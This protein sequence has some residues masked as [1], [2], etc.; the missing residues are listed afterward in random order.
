MKKRSQVLD[1]YKLNVKELFNND[2]EFIKEIDKLKKEIKVISKYEGHLLDDPKTLLEMLDY[3]EEIEKRIEKIYI[4][5]HL[6][7]DMDLGDTKGNE[8]YGIAYKL[9]KDYCT[10]SSYVVPEL[11]EY[12][13]KEIDAF[14]KENEKLKKYERSLK[15]I[16]RLKSHMLSK[17]EEYILT[18]LSDTF[19]APEEIYSKLTDVD[20]KFGTVLDENGSEV[21]L[22]ESNW[23]SFIES[24]DRNVRKNVFKKFFSAY[25]GIINT[26]SELLSN[27]VKKNN[28]VSEI[29]KYDSAMARALDSNEVSP[30][31]Y[32]KL[33]SSIEKNLKTIYRQW[34][35][36]KEKLK[37]DELH[38]YDTYVPLTE[39]F[40]KKYTYEEASKMILDSLKVMGEDYVNTLNRAF[41]EKWIDV[42]PNENKRGGAYCTCCYLTHPYVMTNFNEKY[43]DISTI[44]HEL[45]HAM[46]YYYAQTNNI[47]SDYGYSIFVA[48]VASQVNEILLA[49][50]VLNTSDN[51]EEKIFILDTLMKHFKSSVVRQSMF[52]EFEKNIHESEQNGEILTPEYLCNKYYDLNKKYFGDDVVVDEEIKYEWS[53]IPH[54]Y[55]NF[56]VYQYS[57]G[58]IAAL[59]IAYN[60]YSGDKKALNKYL[61]FLKLGSTKDPVESLKIAGVDLTKDEVYDEAFS[62]LN[63]QMDEF[64]KLI[65]K[66]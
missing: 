53:R 16:F 18:K 19:S 12:D 62:M 28:A 6:I 1:K 42:M 58:Y 57:T 26:T 27:E 59:K 22:T 24:K 14:I 56:Y 65:G 51:K 34:K 61:E 55:Y 49:L 54:F 38:L 44:T 48:E 33:I 7:N 4:Y 43:G 10:L 23:A 47:Y 46:H 32:E 66:E 36:R 52:A 3:S 13:Y 64:E 20:L 63:K 2:E 11:L 37:L 5:A 25:E 40:D 31:V 41:V 39:E 29:R 60:I 21:E 45:G 15:E 30:K 35:I 17:K 8:Y 9:N 50:H